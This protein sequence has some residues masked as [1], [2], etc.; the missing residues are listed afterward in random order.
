MAGGGVC[1]QHERQAT[2]EKTA[3]IKRPE[4]L[5]YFRGRILTTKL[6]EEMKIPE[7]IPIKVD[8]LQKEIK[9]E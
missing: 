9:D 3:D 2:W 5:W 4:A 1:R 8:C 7:I 6:P